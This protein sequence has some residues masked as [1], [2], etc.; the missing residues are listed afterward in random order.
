MGVEFKS[1]AVSNGYLFDKETVQKSVTDWNLKKVQI[2]LDGTETVYNKAKAYIYK[3]TN[4]YRTVME[5]IDHLLTA[6]IA[7]TIRLN[8]SL[9]N[10]EDLIQLV[11]ELA[12]RFGGRRGFF[13]YAD[14]IF[15]VDTPLA[16]SYS[17]EQ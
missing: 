3:N 17:L 13:V 15:E 10:A 12:E 11:N 4:C 8:L 2:T 16:E 9:Y 14:Y 7:V 5:N 1:S 6:G